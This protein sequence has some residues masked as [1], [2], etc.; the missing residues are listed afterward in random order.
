MRR[1]TEHS[2]VEQEMQLRFSLENRDMI[3]P[4]TDD[5]YSRMHEYTT[6]I[7]FHGIFKLLGM[8]TE[9]YTNARHASC[10]MSTNDW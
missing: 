5:S 8:F 6:A 4:L 3:V 10:P 7:S 2:T 1:M 9:I